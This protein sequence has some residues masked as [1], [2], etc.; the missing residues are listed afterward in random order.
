MDS[1]FG[2]IPQALGGLLTSRPGT[3]V[4]AGLLG[5]AWLDVKLGI[6]KD[7]KVI[8]RANRAAAKLAALT[9]TGRWN[10]S[11]RWSES[12]ERVPDRVAFRTPGIEEGDSGRAW[13]Y[14]EA[15]AAID[16]VSNYGIISECIFELTSGLRDQIAKYLK[17]VV[18]VKK[19][20]RVALVFEVGRFAL[21]SFIC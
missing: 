5:A 9:A 18:G 20:D 21:E 14:K 4:A 11:Y 13:T 3:A 1:F 6:S 2:N 16:K 15:D 8:S 19:G 7:L 17:E 10:I 12:V